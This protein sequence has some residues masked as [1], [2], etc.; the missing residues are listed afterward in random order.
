MPMI[1][2]MKNNNIKIFIIKALLPSSEII[3]NALR[4]ETTVY[5]EIALRE[6]IANALIYQILQS[7]EQVR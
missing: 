3:K 1:T 2:L 7:E 5:P 6:L 4:T